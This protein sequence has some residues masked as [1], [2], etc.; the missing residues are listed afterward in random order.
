MTDE[1]DKGDEVEFIP[2]APAAGEGD[3]G[4]PP[5][6]EKPEKKGG[7]EK[8]PA[9][10]ARHLKDKL[11]KR[12]AEIKHLKKDL[13]DLKEAHLRRLAD[14]ENLRKRYDREKTEFQQ[15]ALSGL[16]LELVGIADNFERALQS[17]PPAEGEVKTFREG[18]ELILRMLQN[19]LA[20]QAVRPIVLESR[21]F[22]PNFHHAMMVRESDEVEEPTIEEE[23]QKGYMIHDRLLRP[24]LVRVLLPKKGQ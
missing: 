17:A 11:K 4:A 3:A 5:S 20:K 24:T 2:Q 23:L 16:L 8:E 13:E 21:V 15:Y 10:N 18:V 12:E 14:M 7:E 22:D 19:L 1:K 9:E 6:A